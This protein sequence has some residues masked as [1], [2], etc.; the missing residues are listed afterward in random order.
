MLNIFKR[1]V[2]PRT[3]QCHKQTN[4]DLFD[5]DNIIKSIQTI[6]A[7]DFRSGHICITVHVY[8]WLKK[9]CPRIHPH[10]SHLPPLHFIEFQFQLE[11]LSNDLNE[12]DKEALSWHVG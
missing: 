5:F 7:V 11:V 12:V 3:S 10:P 2:C 1:T 9:G 8:M 6:A 4:F